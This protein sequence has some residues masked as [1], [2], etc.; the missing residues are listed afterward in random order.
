MLLQIG[1][2]RGVYMSLPSC[3]FRV[4]V[5]DGR[6]VCAKYLR[7]MIDCEDEYV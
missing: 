1:G 7:K 2:V 3:E 4:V 6:L 5:D